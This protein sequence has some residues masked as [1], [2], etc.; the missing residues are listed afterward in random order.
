M[1]CKPGGEIGIGEG[2]VKITSLE[3]FVLEFARR[4]E[5]ATRTGGTWV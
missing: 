4:V 3:I 2:V 5:M 1:D